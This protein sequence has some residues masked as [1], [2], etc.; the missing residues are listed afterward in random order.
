MTTWMKT[1]RNYI[2]DMTFRASTVLLLRTQLKIVLPFHLELCWTCPLDL[3][4][5]ELLQDKTR[6]CSPTESYFSRS[7]EAL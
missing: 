7:L 6:L 1:R 2:I 3:S 4:W 5:Q